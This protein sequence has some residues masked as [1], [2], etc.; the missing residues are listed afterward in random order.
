MSILVS[1]LVNSTLAGTII[2][3]LIAIVFPQ[4]NSTLDTYLIQRTG[5]KFYFLLFLCPPLAIQHSLQAGILTPC[6]TS[7]CPGFKELFSVSDFT[8]GVAIILFDAIWMTVAGFYLEAILPQA[9][10]IRKSM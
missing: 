2:G 1:A 5:S 10:G 9:W 7:I 8:I 6:S 4:I 3:Y